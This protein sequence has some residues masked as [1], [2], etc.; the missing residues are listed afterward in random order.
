MRYLLLVSLLFVGCRSGETTY[1]TS[2]APQPAICTV[3]KITGGTQIT[4]PTTSGVIPDPNVVVVP[5]CP[6]ITQPTGGE[7]LF[8]IG[9]TLYGVYSDSHGASERPILVGLHY[10]TTDGRNCHFHVNSDGTVTEDP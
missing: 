8:N 10:I 5:L 9:G 6:E 2:P 3:Q 7:V 4:C 1:I